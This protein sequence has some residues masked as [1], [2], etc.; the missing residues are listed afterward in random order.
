MSQPLKRH[1]GTQR[2]FLTPERGKRQ[3]TRDETKILMKQFV[4]ASFGAG[5]RYSSS[6]NR[7]KSWTSNPALMN[8]SPGSP[9]RVEVTPR[10][11]CYS[12]VASNEDTL[13]HF[14]MA[15][16]GGRQNS[17][18]LGSGI[19]PPPCSPWSSPKLSKALKRRPFSPI[20]NCV[21]FDPSKHVHDVALRTANVQ[22]GMDIY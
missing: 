16:E 2:G 6:E 10:E 7:K 4:S 14:V 21:D 3:C 1:R 13:A 22:S 8:T 17:N 5:I 20:H 11:F 12:L 9:M 18:L 19:R 15:F